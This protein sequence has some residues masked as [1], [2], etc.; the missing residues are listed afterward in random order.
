MSE[1]D[2][3]TLLAEANP[4]RVDG[5]SPMDPPKLSRRRH[6]SRRAVLAVALFAA[7]AVSLIGVF[8]FPGFR[9]NGHARY[10]EPGIGLGT[11]G[12][13]LPPPP[14]SV[15]VAD[16]SVML[17]VPVALP[18]TRTVHPADASS[19]SAEVVC[20]A[21]TPEIDGTCVV[22][23][24][25]PSDSL[26][27]EFWR[28]S[29]A[30]F[31][32][33][34]AGAV[35][36]EKKEAARHPGS[37]QAELLN[38][39]GVSAR[40]LSGDYSLGPEGTGSIDFLVGPHMRV[41]VYGDR[42]EAQLEAAAQS[43]LDGTPSPGQVALTDA[44]SVL[45]APVVLPDTE[46]VHPADGA[47]TATTECLSKPTEAVPCQV[48]VEFP[49][50]V[51]YYVPLT[52]RY[53]RP[54]QADPVAMYQNIAKQ[55]QGAKIVSVGDVSAL[56]VPGPGLTYPSW[57]EFVAGGTDVTVQG[58]YEKSALQAMAQSILDRS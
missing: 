39:N 33:Q 14:T 38:L 44:Q 55:V 9:S 54:V 22:T 29:G 30:P 35:R 50:L 46:A 4:V 31:Q 8:V 11:N 13:T 57:I 20:P 5:L 34:L 19:A 7:V 37:G 10:K 42:S 58:I 16:I 36:Q 48:T 56:Y 21:I 6:S 52:I 12:P 3:M 51:K 26:S 24:K 32:N 17:G 28:P 41:V 27:I 53:L 18:A 2:V 45:G 43:I 25:L 47:P 40:Y 23:V 15:P 49:A 1:R